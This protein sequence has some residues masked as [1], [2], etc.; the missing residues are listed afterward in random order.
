MATL[1]SL[2]KALRQKT[3][4]ATSFP[5]QPLSSKQYSD[6]F[7]IM[8]RSE[9][10]TYED[11]IVPQLSKLI[12]SRFNSRISL[13]VLEIGPG[14]KSVLGYLPSHLRQKIRKYDAFEPNDIFA[15]RLEEW[16]SSTSDTQ[17]PLPCLE[18]SP[19]IRPIPFVLQENTASSTGTRDDAKKYDIIL[20]CH[21]M[22][23]M[24]PKH[25]LIEQTLEMLVKQPQGIIVVFHRDSLRIDDLVCHQS[26]CFPTGVIGLVDNDE[27]LDHFA[28]F[29]AGFTQ[30]S[31]DSP[32]IQVNWREVCRTLGRREEALPD[33]LLFS[34][35]NVMMTFTQHAAK[36]PD[37]TV[38]VPLF[39]AE[40]TVKNW[41]ARLHH[42]A[43]ILSPTDT[44]QV[45]QC[46]QWA[47]KHKTS[48]TVIGGSHSG[49]CT[50]PNVVSI[51][52]SAFDQVH[53]VKEN[54]RNHSSSSNSN[55]DFDPDS[56]PLVIAEAGC[57]TGDIVKRT[58]AEGLTVPLGS[59]PS[60]GAGLWLQG[61]IGHLARQHGLSCDAIVGA[62]IVSVDSSKVLCVGR[63]PNQYLPVEAVRPENEADILWAIKGAGT[64]VG[65]VTSVTF[66]AY[67]AP[68]Y[69]IRNWVVP[70]RDDL[71]ARLK[72]SSFGEFA[73]KLSRNFS[74]DAYLYWDNDQLQLGV[75]MIESTT[76]ELTLEPSSSIDT[77]QGLGGNIKT[78][79]SIGLFDTEMVG[80]WDIVRPLSFTW[81]AFE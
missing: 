14:P 37:L 53:I 5:K 40:K 2:K 46:V 6:G 3:E 45:Q 4:T 65:I 43:S 32:T 68:I 29:I 11:F 49:H 63:V 66:R 8:L 69:S 33:Q 26:T 34:S 70:L 57:K 72:L 50:W 51:D 25:K 78:V 79:D 74:A 54:E 21:S 15:T 12:A 1:E 67:P 52:M 10:K 60:V 30:D 42:P 9:W 22:Y 48:L 7:D 59:R 80:N 23:G 75:T 17:S 18:N 58:M 28:A 39:K 77:F 44:Q 62:V 27:V 73:S 35:P 24:N 61:G 31:D 41:E 64:N 16:L 36:L 20:F 71:E 56:N 13:S 55:S 81:M 19:S 47:L 76:S 38:H